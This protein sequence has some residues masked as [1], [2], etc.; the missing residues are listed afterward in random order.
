[1]GLKS[2]TLVTDIEQLW[3]QG[4]LGTRVQAEYYSCATGAGC[5]LWVQDMSGRCMQGG[6]GSEVAT[7][8]VE[9][10]Q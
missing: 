3:V 8:L 5:G 9:Y 4:E 7:G 6:D 10:T 1:M 2:A